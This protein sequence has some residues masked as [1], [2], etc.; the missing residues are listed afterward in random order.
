M[1]IT[2]NTAT[3]TAQMMGMHTIIAVCQAVQKWRAIHTTPAGWRAV[4]R[5]ES[6]VMEQT[7]EVIIS[8]VMEAVIIEGQM[9]PIISL[10]SIRF[11]ASVYAID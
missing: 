5:L 2:E 7:A 8:L 10:T 6:T 1:C 9:L 11:R 3:H 4:H